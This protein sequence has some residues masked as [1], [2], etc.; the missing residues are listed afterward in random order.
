MMQLTD[1]L[2]QHNDAVIVKHPV[3]L[4]AETLP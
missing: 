2:A 4:Y 1:M 3:E